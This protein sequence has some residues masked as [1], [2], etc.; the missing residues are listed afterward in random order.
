M[1]R[2]GLLRA[3]GICL[4]GTLIV[5][6]GLRRRRPGSPPSRFVMWAVSSSTPPITRDA[7]GPRSAWGAARC[8]VVT[9]M[10]DVPVWCG[11]RIEGLS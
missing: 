8:S 5:P 10:S 7:C 4:T 9:A 2:P 11:D 3:L 1:A 6:A